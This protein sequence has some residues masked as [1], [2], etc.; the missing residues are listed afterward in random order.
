[1]NI[2]YDSSASEH[3]TKALSSLKKA[4]RNALNKKKMLGHYSVIWD[5]E[6]A[7]PKHLH[8]VSEPNKEYN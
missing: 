5:N 1:M 4:V 7:F 2:N 8:Y 3:S 6:T